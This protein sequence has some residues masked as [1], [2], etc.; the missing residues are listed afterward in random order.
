MKKFLSFMI[1]VI[2]I[3]S[4][5]SLG[6]YAALDAEIPQPPKGQS[7]TER[8]FNRLEENKEISLT[9]RTGRT[10]EFGDSYSVINT[11]YLK[12][13]KIAY[14]LNNGFVEIRSILNK[15]NGLTCFFPVF[16]FVHMNVKE[17][18]LGDVDIWKNIKDLSDF[19]MEFLIFA[20][21]YLETID[22]VTYYVED[23]WDRGT[24]TNSFYYVGGELKVLRAVD[25]AYNTTQYTYFDNVT[26]SVEDSVF[27]MPPVSFDI[28]VILKF[29]ISILFSENSST[30]P[31]V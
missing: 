9:F 19:S 7:E 30:V 26:L 20:G 8:F 2:M 1:A 24:V 27:E 5:C 22:G 18:S 14:D 11:V 12:G 31:S 21:A 4:A 23:F 10:K 6:A 3:F 25:T 17:L 29:F 15:D 16:P 13:D 28:S